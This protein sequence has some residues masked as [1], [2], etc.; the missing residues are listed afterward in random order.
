MAES[1][2]S[3]RNP[4]AFFR[5]AAKERANFLLKLL[6]NF[7]ADG[8]VWYTLMYRD[9]FD[10]E[11]TSFINIRR[12]GYTGL[13]ISSDYDV[14]EKYSFRTRIE[15]LLVPFKRGKSMDSEFLELCGFEPEE[16]RVKH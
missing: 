14:A 8:V 7:K 1:Y 11:D 15:L 2:F 9:S 4:D 10:V 13:R 6:N 12:I 16:I 3:K 5:G